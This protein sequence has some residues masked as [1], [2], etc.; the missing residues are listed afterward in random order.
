M[1]PSRQTGY[2]LGL[3]AALVWAATS[4]GIKF[5]LETLGTPALTL[6]FWRDAF[7]AIFLGSCLLL[8]GKRSSDGRSPIAVSRLDLR[9]LAIMGAI[10]IGIYH[11]LWVY[12]IMLNGVALAVVL[13]YT[14]P[15]FVT[16]GSWLFFGAS[17][18]KRQIVALIVSF[19]GCVLLVRAY[20]PSVLQ[21][22]WQGILVGI[23]TGMAHA[24]YV[25]VSQRVV[26]RTSPWVSL[27]WTMFF[28]SLVLLVLTLVLQGPQTL[29][30]VGEGALPWISL[31]ILALGPT[32]GGYGLFTLSLRHIPAPIASLLVIIEAPISSLIAVF[33]L[34]ESLIWPQ[35][36]GMALVFLAAFLPTLPLERLGIRTSPATS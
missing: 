26:S 36:V 6:S 32:L 25:L 33:F 1:Q 3:S 31:L 15:T 12:S 34:N 7:I 23:C 27:M 28:G 22:S 16:I 8:F 5:Q 14:Y 20:D 29:F 17:I 21:T 4:P 13:I 35:V 24:G 30:A 11:A 19:I 2:A 10:S 9:N 18:G